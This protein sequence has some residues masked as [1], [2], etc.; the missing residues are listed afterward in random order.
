[1]KAFICVLC[2]G[3]P[4]LATT[5]FYQELLRVY[6]DFY[7]VV[8]VTDLEDDCISTSTSS[9]T[10]EG[11]KTIHIS[12]AICALAG[13]KGCVAQVNGRACARDK[14]LYY[15]NYINTTP[16][17]GIWFLEEDVFVPSTK[18]LFALD[19]KY[20][21]V[22]VTD[23]LVKEHQPYLGSKDPWYW[24]PSII[25]NEIKAAVLPST[26]WAHAMICA[27]RCSPKMLKAINEY[28]EQ[29]NTLFM[30]EALFNTLA[31]HHGLKICLVKE[32]E[33]IN[34]RLQKELCIK[35]DVQLTHLYHPVKTV[36]VHELLRQRLRGYKLR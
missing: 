12:A 24:W 25:K 26:C 17:L 34:W 15:F 33:H 6:C 14:A 5:T 16:Y 30:D 28:A 11:I 21:F 23:L 8:F 29:N 36:Q 31:T 4:A 7:E 22:G 3:E 19:Q 9:S 2:T 18:T 20:G 32:L 10:I 13:Y 35:D 1:M 27:I